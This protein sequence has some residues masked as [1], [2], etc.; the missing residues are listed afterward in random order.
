M[1]NKFFIFPLLLT[2]VSAPSYSMR[3]V[4]HT[5]TIGATLYF[6]NNYTTAHYISDTLHQAYAFDGIDARANEGY[7]SLVMKPSSNSALELAKVRKTLIKSLNNSECYSASKKAKIATAIKKNMRNIFPLLIP[8]RWIA[9]SKNGDIITFPC[10]M[11]PLVPHSC[12][13]KFLCSSCPENPTEPFEVSLAKRME[14]F[15]NNPV[16]MPNMQNAYLYAFDN[17]LITITKNKKLIHGANGHFATASTTV[18]SHI[19]QE[20]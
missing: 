9:N 2:L 8:A 5:S 17:N 13:T 14:T 18:S 3:T 12:T 7:V 11:R 20:K 6:D 1:K 16:M 4:A 10:D 19:P 15:R